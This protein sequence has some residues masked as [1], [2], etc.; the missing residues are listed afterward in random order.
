MLMFTVIESR[1]RSNSQSPKSQRKIIHKHTRVPFAARGTT[2]PYRTLAVV[3]PFPF[4]YLTCAEILSEFF[5]GDFAVF[6]ILMTSPA[7]STATATATTGTATA[8]TTTLGHAYAHFGAPTHIHVYL[9]RNLNF[10]ITTFSSSVVVIFG[11]VS[12]QLPLAVASLP[13]RPEECGRRRPVGGG[14]GGGVN[15][16]GRR[17]PGGGSCLAASR[18]GLL[19]AKCQFVTQRSQI[20]HWAARAPVLDL[21]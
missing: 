4:D 15:C 16:R 5:S 11:L 6:W 2:L 10:K 18:L 19:V 8:A 3:T 21:P 7:T 20:R 17:P 12:P 13:V 9:Y 14:G 1:S